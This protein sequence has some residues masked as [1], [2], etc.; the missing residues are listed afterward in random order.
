MATLAQKIQCEQDARDMVRRQGLPEPDAVEYGETCIRLFWE[1][2]KVVLVV[3]ID[4]PPEGFE[5]VGDYIDDLGDLDLGEQDQNGHHPDYDPV[6]E[7]LER[8]DRGNYDEQGE[9]D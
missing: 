2:S 6:A 9:M 8:L 3:E 7:E 4:K 1:K 5:V